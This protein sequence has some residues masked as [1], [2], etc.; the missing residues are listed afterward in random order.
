MM[1]STLISENRHDLSDS[2]PFF[3]PLDQVQSAFYFFCYKLNK[4]ERGFSG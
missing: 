1:I 2:N 4:I 3:N